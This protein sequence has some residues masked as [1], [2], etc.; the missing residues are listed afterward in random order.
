M[1][2]KK[3]QSDI[4]VTKETC[5][6]IVA[7]KKARTIA[8]GHNPRFA[9]LDSTIEQLE[10]WVSLWASESGL[11]ETN[12]PTMDAC[13]RVLDNYQIEHRPYA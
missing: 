7:L 4:D 1:T 12:D 9:A 10:E 6:A 3:I 8:I 11:Q 2:S 5:E 13:I